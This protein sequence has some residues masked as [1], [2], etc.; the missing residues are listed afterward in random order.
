MQNQ[1]HQKN[2]KSLFLSQYKSETQPLCFNEWKSQW[3]WGTFND[4]IFTID[5]FLFL[6]KTCRFSQIS[7]PNYVRALEIAFC[8]FIS[9]TFTVWTVM[10]KYSQNWYDIAS[11]KQCL[12]KTTPCELKFIS[13]IFTLQFSN[14]G[15]SCFSFIA[16]EENC[17]S[18]FSI[19]KFRKVFGCLQSFTKFM[20]LCACK[21]C[22]SQPRNT[23][24]DTFAH[25][26]SKI[27]F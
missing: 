2:G 14:L 6:L 8:I 17:F 20:I 13:M 21:W 12:L 9:R 26:P 3:K 24:H 4:G 7:L 23:T 27:M 10:Q 1:E 5:V 25:L 15:H 16:L 22:R 11:I 19:M 18:P